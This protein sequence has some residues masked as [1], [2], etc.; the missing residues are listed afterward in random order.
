MEESL[1]VTIELGRY[2]DATI[3]AGRFVRNTVEERNRKCKVAD[4]DDL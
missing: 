3:L 2:E 1:R 4:K